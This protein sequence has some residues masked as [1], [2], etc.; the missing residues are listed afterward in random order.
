MKN[1]LMGQHLI[2]RLTVMMC[3]FTVIAVVSCRDTYDAPEK[4]VLVTGVTL[5]PATK[6]VQLGVD[7]LFEI[8]AAVSPANASNNTVTWSVYPEG[9]VEIMPNSTGKMAMINIIS[10]GITTVTA[11]ANGKT[12]DGKPRFAECKITVNPEGGEPLIYVERVELDSSDFFL[13]DIGETKLL[14]AAVYPE[15]AYLRTV[16]WLSTKPEVASVDNGLVKALGYGQAVIYATSVGVN[17]EGGHERDSVTVTILEPDAPVIY[18]DSITLNKYSLLMKAGNSETLVATVL[19]TGTLGLAQ[20]RSDNASIAEVDGNGKITAHSAGTTHITAYSTF[21]EDNSEVSVSCSVTVTESSFAAGNATPAASNYSPIPVPAGNW[22]RYEAEDAT[23]VAMQGFAQESFYSGGDAVQLKENEGIIPSSINLDTWRTTSNIGYIH[24]KVYVQ[25][26]GAYD[27]NLIYIGNDTKQLLVQLNNDMSHFL[28]LPEVQGISYRLISKRFTIGHFE[29]GWND[30]YISGV[31]GQQWMNVDCIDVHSLPEPGTPVTGIT[32]DKNNITLKMGEKTTE[33]LVPTISPPDATYKGVSWSVV[34]DNPHGCITL[35]QTGVVTAIEPGTATVL[36]TTNDGGY[37]A[38]CTVKVEDAEIH[39]FVNTIIVTPDSLKMSVGDT[40]SPLAY[41]IG[42][43]EAT[44][45]AVTWHSS[46]ETIATVSSTGVVTAKALGTANIYVQSTY[47]SD[48]L[49]IVSNNCVVTVLATNQLTGFQVGRQSNGTFITALPAANWT[50]YEAEDADFF[51]TAMISS[52]DAQLFSGG[53]NVTKLSNNI[54]AASFPSNWA[55][56][57][58]IKFTVYVMEDG[59]YDVD[60][61]TT[62]PDSKT[63]FIKVNNDPHIAHTITYTAGGSHSTVYAIRFKLGLLKAGVPN[64]ILISGHVGTYTTVPD[65]EP[66]MN[67]DCIDVNSK[68]PDYTPVTGISLDR[69]NLELEMGVTPSATLTV[70]IT[71]NDAT[72][73]TINWAVTNANPAGC[74]T[75]N[76]GLVTAIQAGTATVIATAA[77]TGDGIKTASCSVTITA[78]SSEVYVTG[79]TVSPASYHILAGK[80]TTLSAEIAPETATNKVIT[81]HSSNQAVA[82]VN[83]ST[84][85]VTAVAAGTAN[86]YAQSAHVASGSPIVSNNCVLM[87][88]TNQLLNNVIVNSNNSVYNRPTGYTRY[89]PETTGVGAV[90]GG[91]RTF[92]KTTLSNGKGVTDFGNPHI[93]TDFPDNWK[94]NSLSPALR[95][96]EVTI[97]VSTAG[98]YQVNII[99]EGGDT[100]PVVVKVNDAP[101]QI[102][103]LISPSGASWQCKYALQLRLTL[104][105]GANTISFAVAEPGGTWMDVDCIDVRN[106]A[107]QFN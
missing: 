71:P 11:A 96:V 61:I 81:W 90:F 58:H 68:H 76:N 65:T 36:V 29:Q 102:H 91:A 84:G 45:K 104:K 49:P 55:G 88:T 100:K 35:S 95:F 50:R 2:F 5:N 41:L 94:V 34:A 40:S 9:I 85:V 53:K 16:T 37:T 51:G 99:Y 1:L 25:T 23:L 66:W 79:I 62:G 30:L 31:V 48:G 39:I 13:D 93:G 78:A 105:S 74:V 21:T 69:N 107:G 92:D 22:T 70:T 103:N 18:V 82:T 17:E 10:H 72:N 7:G 46:N 38:Q 47:T 67:I 89:E 42:P 97:S 3:I 63:I 86:I 80:T 98:D 4:A 15:G 43:D 6:T 57:N 87:V 26:A 19:P 83:S 77:D 106:T 73:K 44:N 20:W 75:V 59:E 14:T 24:F 60:L 27:V 101:H 32:L 33:T 64:T 12:S 56:I 52:G 28:D 54:T 8:T